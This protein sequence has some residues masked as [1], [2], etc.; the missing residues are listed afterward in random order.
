VRNQHELLLIGVRGNMRS[1]AEG[2]RPPSIIDAP[3]RE[4]SQK[5]EEA[6]QLIERMYPDLPK[7]ELFARNARAGWVAWGNQAPGPDDGLDISAS[8]RRAEGSAS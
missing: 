1:P 7:C 8:P 4:H 3:R 6:Y 2:A 5:P